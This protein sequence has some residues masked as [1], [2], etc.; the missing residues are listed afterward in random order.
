MSKGNLFLGMARGKVGDV[1]FSRHNGEQVARARNRAP[2]NPQTPLQLLQRVVLKTAS[3]AY[4]LMQ[5]IADHSF[6]GSQQGT[7]NQSRFIRVNVDLLR[8]K[9]ADEINSGD[10]EVI[11]GSATANFSTKGNSLAEMN[12]YQVSEGSIAPV[13]TNWDGSSF[14]LMLTGISSEVTTLTYQNVIDALGLQRGDQLTFIWLST[15]DR[16]NPEAQNSK[17]NSFVY[18][19]VILE[20]A[21][22]NMDGAFIANGAVS[23]PNERNEGLIGL[24][25]DLSPQSEERIQF[26]NPSVV[27]AAGNARSVA[28]AAVIVSRLNGGIWA[29]ST[30]FL[31]LRPSNP[32]STGHLNFDAEADYLGDAILSFMT[33]ATSSLYLNQAESF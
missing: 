13:Q 26:T 7:P 20:P 17:F 8:A 16:S 33:E 22:G 28:G 6:Q 4:S 31:T 11:I 24:V 27:Q 3:G 9:L 5:E 2:K 1:V 25:A 12:A 32:A 10:P 23:Q 18:S 15:D 29:R 14:A 21:D 30:Q 19:R